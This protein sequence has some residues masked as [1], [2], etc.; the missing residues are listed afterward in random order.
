[1]KAQRRLRHPVMTAKDRRFENLLH[2]TAELLNRRN[3]D[4]GPRLNAK[5]R[6]SSSR[7]VACPPVRKT[8]L[9]RIRN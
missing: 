8:L 7:I 1:M 6:K 3:S 9:G 5:K 2:R 4:L